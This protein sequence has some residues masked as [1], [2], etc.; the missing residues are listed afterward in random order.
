M[1]ALTRLTL[2]NAIY[3]RANWEV[4]F[5]KRRTQVQPFHLGF[6]NQVDVKM[7]QNNGDFKTGMISSLGA[8]VLELPYKVGYKDFFSKINLKKMLEFN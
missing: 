8:R 6:K 1:D 4:P 5:E 7:M 2:V 3:F